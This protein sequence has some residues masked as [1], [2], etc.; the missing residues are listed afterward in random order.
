MSRTL[1]NQMDNTIDK[2]ATC[3]LNYP[4]TPTEAAILEAAKWLQFGELREGCLVWTSNRVVD[5]GK[6]NRI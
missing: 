4:L 1:A 5:K 6:N 3:V 2:T